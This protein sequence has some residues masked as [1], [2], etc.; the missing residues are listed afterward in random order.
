MK[1]SLSEAVWSPGGQ[2]EAEWAEGPLTGYYSER[3]R[4]RRK[5]MQAQRPLEKSPRAENELPVRVG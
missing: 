4:G 3:G 2:E 5:N 1:T